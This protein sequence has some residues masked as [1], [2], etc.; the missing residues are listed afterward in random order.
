MFGALQK[1]EGEAVAEEAKTAEVT[2]ETKAETSA[3]DVPKEAAA[4]VTNGEPEVVK[5]VEEP[6]KEESGDVPSAA[7]ATT[8]EPPKVPELPKVV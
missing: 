3:A 4:V 2:E 5:E 6:K 1:K 8:D 7:A